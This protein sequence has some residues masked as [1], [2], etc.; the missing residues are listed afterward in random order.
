[1]NGLKIGKAIKIIFH[2]NKN[3]YPL[4]ADQGA[5]YPFIIYRRTGVKHADTKDRFNFSEEIT[6][7]I[8]VASNTYSECLDEAQRVMWRM[9]NTRGTYNDIKIQEIKLVDA[10]EDYIEDAYIQKLTFKIEII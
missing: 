9:E 8:I 10:S 2:D 7:E 3:I 6:L 1:M 5:E 4:V